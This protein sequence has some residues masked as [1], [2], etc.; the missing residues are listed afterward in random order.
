MNM[1]TTSGPRGRMYPNAKVC[2]GFK[3]IIDS[4]RHSSH[5]VETLEFACE[6]RPYII[7]TTFIYF[8]FP[9]MS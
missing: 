9:I 5:S 1:S 7:D 3:L 4:S 6:A 8:E 2:S